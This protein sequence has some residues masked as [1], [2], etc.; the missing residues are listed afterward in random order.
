MCQVK[1]SSNQLDKHSSKEGEDWKTLKSNSEYSFSAHPQ[2]GQKLHPLASHLLDSDSCPSEWETHPLGGRGE[3]G[4]KGGI[5]TKKLF[6]TI[7]VCEGDHFK[8]WSV[9]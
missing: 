6:Q 7:S 9:A 8:H 4:G 3:R 5:G 2:M 1:K